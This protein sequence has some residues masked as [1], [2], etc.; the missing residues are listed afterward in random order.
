MINYNTEIDTVALQIDCK[1]IKRQRYS[2]DIIRR[3]IVPSGISSMK[4]NKQNNKHEVYY[5]N[6]KF[7][8]I[9][10]GY[11]YSSYYIRIRFAGLKSYRDVI[12]SKS[13][14][15]LMLLCGWLKST[16]ILFRLVELDIAID[17]FC[18]FYNILVA[19]TRKTPHVPYNDVGHIQSFEN[20]PTS[21]IEGYTEYEERKNATSR[22]YVYNKS[23]K[24]GLTFDVTRFELKLQNKYF[25]RFGCNAQSIIGALS[26]YHV[27]YFSNKNEKQYIMKRLNSDL[28]TLYH[29]NHKKF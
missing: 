12:D 1:D 10:T 8:T 14:M 5:G 4:F 15:C 11:T 22:S 21:Y 19:C 24:E 18:P 25:K 27:M 17:I 16:G 13:K 2:L 26:K 23:A 7:A 9:S 28:S 20:V 3:C 6:T 29:T